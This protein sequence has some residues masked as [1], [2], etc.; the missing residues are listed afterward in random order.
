M[1]VLVL[2]LC[3]TLVS[4][5]STNYLITHSDLSSLRKNYYKFLCKKPFSLIDFFLPWL[6]RRLVFF[7]FLGLDE[8]HL[9]D[10]CEKAADN[11]IFGFLNKDI[12]QVF[13]DGRWDLTI[14]AT[15]S[16]PLL[17]EAIKEK[18]HFSYVVAGNVK[19]S[20]GVFLGG[21]LDDV[22]GQKARFVEDLLVN[23]LKIDSFE[24]HAYS[25]NVEDSDLKL[26]SKH[27]FKV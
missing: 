13:V 4:V 16:F 2:D 21:V 24:I 5:N 18:L 25:D 22:Y 10:Y 7:T 8:N 17:G 9:R 11:I 26:I 14:L 3:G 20:R 19:F 27:F 23:R 6:F 12:Y 1:R 15:A